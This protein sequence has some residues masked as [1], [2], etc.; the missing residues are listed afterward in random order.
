MYNLQKGT[1]L[2]LALIVA[3]VSDII[4]AVD[5]IPAVFGVTVDPLIVYSSNMFAIISLRSMF[6]FV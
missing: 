5:S 6:G 3:E 1:P 2:L 4:F